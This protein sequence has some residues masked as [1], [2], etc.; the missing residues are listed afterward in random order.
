MHEADDRGGARV[1]E[2]QGLGE[3]AGADAARG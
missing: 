1:G 3:Q 2:L